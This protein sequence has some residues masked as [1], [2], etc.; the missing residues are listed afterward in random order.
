MKYVIKTG[1]NIDEA[2]SE[3]LSELNI[4]RDE[5]K[6]EVLEEG[7][8]GFLGIIG[9]KEATVKVTKIEDS[10]EDILKEIFNED[11]EKE[12]SH[13]EPTVHTE[14]ENKVSPSEELSL[15]NENENII[16]T[17]R[18][19][20]DKIIDSLGLEAEIEAIL[21]EN[22]LK[23][24]VMGDENKL[25]IIIGKRGATLDSIQ[26]ILNLIVNK[27]A[28]R[29]IKVSLDSSG[30]REKRKET[31]EELANKM[32]AKVLRTNHSIRLEPMNAYER[33]I[34]HES[35]QDYEGILTHSEGKDPFRKV[36]IQKERK[37]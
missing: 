17:A 31:L 11:I 10:T 15:D 27:K 32:A 3:A 7:T 20:M 26:Y 23:I 22:L 25:G 8:K 24:N 19:F 14:I 1:K 4:S 33:K 21:E 18:E 36:V 30:Y 5:A 35:L 13:V 34:I 29:Y 28:S 12:E 37:Y 6:I 2:V 9:N 16:K